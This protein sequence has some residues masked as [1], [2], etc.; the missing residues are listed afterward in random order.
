MKL[1]RMCTG[2]LLSWT[3]DPQAIGPRRRIVQRPD[4]NRCV[5]YS[6]NNLHCHKIVKAGDCLNIPMSPVG[7][8]SIASALL[9]SGPKMPITS[10]RL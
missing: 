2:R 9:I 7:Y 10:S 4:P 6:H 3:A 1:P 8:N 5:L